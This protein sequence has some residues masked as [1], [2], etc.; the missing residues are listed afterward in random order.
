MRGVRVA[1]AA[2]GSTLILAAALGLAPNAGAA[3]SKPLRSIKPDIVL[4]P[5]EAPITKTVHSVLVGGYQQSWTPAQCRT[6]PIAATNCDVYR[7]KLNLSRAP[8][9]SNFVVISVAYRDVV[10]P[11][12][13]LTDQLAVTPTAVPNLDMKVYYSPDQ[14]LAVDRNGGDNLSSPERVNFVPA[15]AEYDVV[16]ESYLGVATSY[17]IS[18]FMTDG[19]YPPPFEARD[20]TSVVAVQAPLPQAPPRARGDNSSSSSFVKPA[21]GMW[22][23]EDSELKGISWD[24]ADD[25]PS[26]VSYRSAA[27][28]VRAT[29]SSALAPLLAMG[30]VPGALA[31]AAVVVVRRRRDWMMPAVD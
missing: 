8:G 1:A 2:V 13:V 28:S 26:Q 27:R 16:V 5:D 24:I 12:V 11:P 4:T 25:F 15:K 21:L 29:H 14:Y 18:A 31:I 3:A 7:V 20:D 10:P 23:S 22:G 17:E 6:N 19:L 9:A 30:V